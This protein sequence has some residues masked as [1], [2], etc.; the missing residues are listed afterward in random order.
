MGVLICASPDGRHFTI[1]VPRQPRHDV[2]DIVVTK[3]RTATVHSL[4]DR[5]NVLTDRAHRFPRSR[6]G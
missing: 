3:K 5:L 6:K 4:H 1:R 2:I